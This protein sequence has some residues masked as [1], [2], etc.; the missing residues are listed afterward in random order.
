M[1]DSRLHSGNKEDPME[2]REPLYSEGGCRRRQGYPGERVIGGEG[3]TINLQDT[4]GVGSTREI[5]GHKGVRVG[6]LN[7]DMGVLGRIG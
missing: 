3:L 2:P 4:E 1:K 6:S 7:G 5:G